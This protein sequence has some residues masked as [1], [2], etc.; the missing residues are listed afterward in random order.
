MFDKRYWLNY[1]LGATGKFQELYE[2]LDN[3]DAV[4]CG[5][6]FAT[7]KVPKVAQTIEDELRK[8]LDLDTYP[9][10]R[11]YLIHQDG[12]GV[13]HGYFIIGKRKRRAIWNGAAF[14]EEDVVD[15]G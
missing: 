14:V 9:D 8:L 13:V 3:L 4:E 1:D 10:A 7:F 15:E 2:W 12:D 6:G 11:I 5:E